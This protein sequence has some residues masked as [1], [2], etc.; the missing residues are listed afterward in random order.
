[1]IA[2]PLAGDQRGHCQD[3]SAPLQKD[4]N[5]QYHWVEGRSAQ[6][7]DNRGEP[8][9]ILSSFHTI[10]AQIHAEKV[11]RDRARYDELT[12]LINRAEVFGRLRTLLTQQP[13]T[14]HETAVAFCDLDAFKD[15]NDTYGRKWGLRPQSAC[16][17]DARSLAGT[18]LIARIG[19]DEIPADPQWHAQHLK[20][21]WGWLR[22]S[23]GQQP[24]SITTSTTSTR[25]GMSIGV[26]LVGPGEGPRR[27]HRPRR[28]C[29]VQGQS[30][31]V[32]NPD[33]R[34]LT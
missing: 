8:D 14:G 33:H 13:R 6:F 18:T 2:V 4:K 9:G 15:I 10:D 23:D 24:G 5:G 20:P 25:R 1:M 22:R 16:R 21:P 3:H 17:G 11:L 34:Q 28:P 29:D 30:R 31:R 12:G 26:A 19:G 32:A 27:C 7:I